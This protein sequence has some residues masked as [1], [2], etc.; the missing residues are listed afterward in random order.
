VIK[1]QA[2]SGSNGQM[3]EDFTANIKIY[4]TIIVPIVLCFSE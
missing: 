2:G 4:K 3:M 1:P